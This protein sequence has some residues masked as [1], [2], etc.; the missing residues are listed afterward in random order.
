MLFLF[1]TWAFLFLFFLYFEVKRMR[2]HL[3]M[4]DYCAFNK[5]TQLKK[6]QNWSRK[7]CGGGGKEERKTKENV[8]VWD[9]FISQP[10]TYLIQLFRILKWLLHLAWRKS[11][12]QLVATTRWS[13]ESQDPTYLVYANMHI[14]PQNIHSK[15]PFVELIIK[16]KVQSLSSSY[17]KRP[18]ACTRMQT[19]SSKMQ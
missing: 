5:G 9:F 19:C 6:C 12:G 3:A 16:I 13:F 1:F 14:K 17:S 4:P 10:R 11:K 18:K 8:P 7:N 15:G 2:A